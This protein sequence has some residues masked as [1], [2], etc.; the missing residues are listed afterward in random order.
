MAYTKKMH[1]SINRNRVTGKCTIT[2]DL[3][4]EIERLQK[5][6]VELEKEVEEMMGEITW[7]NKLNAEED[8]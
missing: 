5:R 4:D 3:I 7:Y 8:W 6:I 2:T 1:D